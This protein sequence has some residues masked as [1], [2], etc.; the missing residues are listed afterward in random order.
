M[1][2][3]VRLP[4]YATNVDL[5]AAGMRPSVVPSGY[6]LSP[7]VQAPDDYLARIAKYVPAEVIAFSLFINAILDQAV[8]AGGPAAT[9]AGF[10]VASIAQIALVAG[11]VLTPLFVWYVREEGDA[12]ITNAVVSTLLFP[13]WA[14]AMGAVAFADYR[15]GNLAAILLATVTVVS[16]FISPRVPRASR[17]VD[18]PASAPGE[19]VR[20]LDSRASQTLAAQ[21][22]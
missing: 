12:W 11:I 21:D 19:N 6:A 13:F 4:K 10:P 14:Y 2:R 20:V 16:G 22:L 18:K 17:R 1:G 3:L 8:R 9:M 7:V 15:D 5:P